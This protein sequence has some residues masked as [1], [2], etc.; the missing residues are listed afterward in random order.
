MDNAGQGKQTVTWYWMVPFAL[1][2][3]SRKTLQHTFVQI[4]PLLGLGKGAG[5]DVMGSSWQ[6]VFMPT[7]IVQ[8]S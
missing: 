8:K 6:W 5:G 2:K 1:R 4:M 7:H 3:P